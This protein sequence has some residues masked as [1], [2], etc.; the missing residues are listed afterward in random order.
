MTPLPDHP[1]IDPRYEIRR[2][3][4]TRALA[5]KVTCPHCGAERWYP[6]CTLRQQI[7]RPNFNGQCKP[8]GTRESRAG[9]FQ[10]AKRNGIA[11][12][13]TTANGYIVIGPTG[14]PPEDLPLFRA[15]QTRAH[16]VLE[17]RLVMAKHLGRPL[18]SD[19]LVDHMNGDKTDNRAEN[20]RVYV[21]GKQQPGSTNG[22]GTYYHEWQ[23]AERRVREL[24]ARLVAAGVTP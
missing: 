5:A 12:R 14:V 3:Y 15:M 2:I 4:K 16:F 6:L 9:Y 19:E 11:R 8:C 24:E 20:L 13:S 18:R 1:A 10:W 22:Y 21:R 17:H 23:L 7:K